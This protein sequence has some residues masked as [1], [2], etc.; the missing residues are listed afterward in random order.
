MRAMARDITRTKSWTWNFFAKSVKYSDAFRKF[1]GRDGY[2]RNLFASQCLK[3][4]KVLVTR[5]R[6]IDKATGVISSRLRANLGIFPVDADFETTLVLD[7]ITGSV[8]QHSESWDLRRMSFP[9]KLAFTATRAAW[10]AT[11]YAQDLAARLKQ[12]QQDDQ[13]NNSRQNIS[14][15]PTDPTKFFQQEDPMR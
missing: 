15:D 7:L 5:M 2:K 9:A 10:S 8:L 6:M 11:Q 13:D 14:R 1:E 4:P 12:M 3:D